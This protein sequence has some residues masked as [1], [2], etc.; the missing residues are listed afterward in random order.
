MSPKEK[1]NREE[2]PYKCTIC[3]KAFHRLEHQTRHIRT[4]TGEKPHPCT[5]PGCVKR[6]SRSDELTRHLRIHNNPSGRKRKNQLQQ[7]SS[8]DELYQLPYVTPTVN[9]PAL[10]PSYQPVP[11]AQTTAIP[12]TIDNNGIH[13][14]HQ[15]YPVYFVQQPPGNSA[16]HPPGP[17]AG[18]TNAPINQINGHAKF[19]L[20]SSPTNQTF[21]PNTPS[22]AISQDG[23]NRFPIVDSPGVNRTNNILEK[24]ESNSSIASQPTIFSHHSNNTSLSTSPDSYQV[25][26]HQVKPSFSNLNEYFKS[27]KPATSSSYLSLNNRSSSATNLRSFNSLTRL[28]PI[29]PVGN[30]VNQ[31]NSI[32]PK[33]KSSTSLNLEFYHH[34]YQPAKKSRP[35]SPNQSSISLGTSTSM[36]SNV[37]RNP[38]FIISPNET[39]LH[40]PLQSPHL[41][42]ILSRDDLKLTQLNKKLMENESIVS[43]QFDNNLQDDSIALHSIQLPPIRSVFSFD[44]LKNGPGNIKKSPIIQKI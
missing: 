3:D 39:P 29:K 8:S 34:G 17:P 12:V 11:P 20:P 24:S 16:F 1:K 28:T 18:F 23:T 40:T 26:Y 19:S 4:H 42:P 22:R 37:S 33:P 13:I 15:P 10:N 41:Q 31:P 38:G 9:A 7:T 30:N 2:R 43:K 27:N 25:S 32:L 21:R 5:F 14:Y 35:N 44:N 6:F 36:T